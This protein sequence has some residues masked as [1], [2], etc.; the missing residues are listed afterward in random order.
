MSARK[1]RPVLYELIA[2]TGLSHPAVRPGPPPSAANNRA[3]AEESPA[4]GESRFAHDEA[5]V[6]QASGFTPPLMEWSQGRLHLSL[7]WIHFVVLGVVFVAVVAGVF[8]AGRRSATPA[9]ANSGTLDEVLSGL[10]EQA[11]NGSADSGRSEPR[12]PPKPGGAGAVTP[13]RQGQAEHPAEPDTTEPNETADLGPTQ[14]FD[15]KPGYSYV[16]VQCVSRTAVGLKYAEGI[17][18]FLVSK[19]VDCAIHRRERDAIVLVTE[20]F[21]TKQSNAAAAR[22]EKDRADQLVARIK[23]LG[24][25]YNLIGRFS[26]DKCFV[27]QPK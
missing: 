13:L 12:L 18:D 20:P 8:Q 26:F 22:Q 14:T 1:N 2:R 6:G 24:K 15:F 16:I 23:E 4:G 9:P 10:P 27:Q 5:G 17:R 3:R 7:G 11:P 19:G 25:E 21:L